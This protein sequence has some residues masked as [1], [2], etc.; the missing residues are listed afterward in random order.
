M[1]SWRNKKKNIST[2]QLKKCDLSGTLE[3]AILLVLT[4][5]GLGS[6]VFLIWILQNMIIVRLYPAF[7]ESIPGDAQLD[8]DNRITHSRSMMHFIAAV[9]FDNQ[10]YNKLVVC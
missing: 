3:N 4:C 8:S 10:V 9:K 6:N 7:I 5:P 2:F 1:F